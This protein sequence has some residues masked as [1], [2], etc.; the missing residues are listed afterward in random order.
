MRKPPTER[1]DHADLRI[2]FA[3]DVVSQ[4]RQL[5]IDC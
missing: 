2:V 5:I 3:A 1:D 4:A